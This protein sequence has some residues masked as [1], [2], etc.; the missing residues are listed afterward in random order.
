[1]ATA[2]RRTATR[3]ELTPEDAPTDGTMTPTGYRPRF[4]T[5]PEPNI[6]G[7][8]RP[9]FPFLPTNPFPTE[10]KPKDDPRKERDDFE[11]L[12]D[13][14][15]R[16]LSVPTGTQDATPTV[17][18]DPN[19]GSGNGMNI[20]GILILLGVAALAWFAWKKWGKKAVDSAAA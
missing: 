17:I 6:P 5:I 15:S 19:S 14:F 10:D 12:A 4:P 3:R 18:M 7:H 1:M 11:T 20:K 16:V 13:A 8:T 9:R 2:V